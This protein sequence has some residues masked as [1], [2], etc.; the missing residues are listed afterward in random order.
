VLDLRKCCDHFQLTSQWRSRRN[1]LQLAGGGILSV[2]EQRTRLA[3]A[4]Q[5]KLQ[6]GWRAFLLAR[7]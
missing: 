2:A 3:D 7:L 4:L 1:E 6:V 5:T